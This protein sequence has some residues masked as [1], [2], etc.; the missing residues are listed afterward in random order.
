M[1][2][3]PI[4]NA[5]RLVSFPVP[6]SVTGTYQLTLMPGYNAFAEIYWFFPGAVARSR[7]H[8]PGGDR[9][10]PTIVVVVVVGLYGIAD[11]RADYDLMGVPF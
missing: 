6:V 10:P 11:K 9:H 7:T 8:I 1:S 3:R 5:T 2:P 4:T